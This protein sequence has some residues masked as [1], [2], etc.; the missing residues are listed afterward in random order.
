MNQSRMKTLKMKWA[1]VIP[2]STTAFKPYLS[3]DHE[4]VARHARWLVN[5]GC[6]GIGATGG[7]TTN[8]T[9]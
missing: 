5:I 7:S 1:G 3:A 8:Q 6:T 2:A 4:L 9:T